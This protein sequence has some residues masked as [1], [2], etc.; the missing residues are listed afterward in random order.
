MAKFTRKDLITGDIVETRDGDLG[1]VITEKDH[2]YFK[3]GMYFK[4]SQWHEETLLD[5]CLGDSGSDVMRVYRNA[6]SFNIC[7]RPYAKEYIVYDRNRDEV[8]EMTLEEVCKALGK[9]IKIVKEHND[10]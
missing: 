2:V 9:N 7:R 6:S 4:V 1:V 10:D 5:N 3:S 8:E